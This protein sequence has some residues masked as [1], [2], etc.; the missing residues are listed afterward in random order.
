M[1]R[2]VLLGAAFAAS[3]S[4][5]ACR[6]AVGPSDASTMTSG[7]TRVGTSAVA[8]PTAAALCVDTINQYRATLGLAA[9]ARW[10]DAEGCA[11]GQ[12]QADAVSG[13]P[14]SAFGRCLET[15]QNE[16]P[17]WSGTAT[18]IIGGCLGVMW[19]EGPGADF[20]IHGHYINMSSTS[21]TK[22]ACGFFTTASGQ[23]WAAQDLK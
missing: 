14:H 22:V 9:Y 5:G 21:Y 23:V 6:G 13:I 18:S 1:H 12:S 8:T 17:G 2:A 4:L 7:D 11:D 20:S 15:A 3:L 16:C 19:A 10:T